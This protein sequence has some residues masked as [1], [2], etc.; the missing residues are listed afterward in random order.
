MTKAEQIRIKR[1]GYKYF[2]DSI[3]HNLTNLIYKNDLITNDKVFSYYIHK[4]F[5]IN[6]LVKNW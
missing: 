6:K 5:E 2:T 1:Q 3:M 4:E